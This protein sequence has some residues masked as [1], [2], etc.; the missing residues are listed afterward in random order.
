MLSFFS[1]FSDSQWTVFKLL[2]ERLGWVAESAIYVSSV[3][4]WRLFLWVRR[5]LKSFSVFPGKILGLL[6]NNFWH[7]CQIRIYVSRRTAHEKTDVSKIFQVLYFEFNFSDFWQIVL[8]RIV[9]T[10]FC[11]SN[12]KFWRKKNFLEEFIS[13][14]FPDLIKKISKTLAKEVMAALTKLGLRVQKTNLKKKN[15]SKS[16][17]LF[18]CF[19][20][21]F[22]VFCWIVELFSRE[23]SELHPRFS[24]IH[25]EKTC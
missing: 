19:K 20:W 2:R 5:L 1:F 7:G 18:W 4:F 9:K 25:F 12:E 14:F 3:A 6:A 24:E 15:F 23:L 21:R 11:D 13:N 16:F 8:G 10:L 17:L 22:A